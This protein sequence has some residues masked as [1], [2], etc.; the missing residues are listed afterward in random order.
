MAGNETVKIS[1]SSHSF[2][3]LFAVRVQLKEDSLSLPLGIAEAKGSRR[4][5]TSA[6]GR[7]TMVI[8]AVYV[9]AP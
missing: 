4:E 1:M 3:L 2:V 8:G 6:G 7:C 9:Q 5:A